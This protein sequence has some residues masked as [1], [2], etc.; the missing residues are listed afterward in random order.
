MR[1]LFMTSLAS[2]AGALAIAFGM[3]LSGGLVTAQDGG[4]PTVT[5]DDVPRPAH[6]HF[7]T[8][9]DLGNIAFP[10][11]D[12]TG[13]TIQG[14]PEAS[15]IVEDVSDPDVVQGEVV[16]ES[17]TDVESNWDALLDETAT[18]AIN[19]HDSADNMGLYIACGD[20]TGEPQDGRLEIDLQ[21]L[22]DSGFSGG[23]V[24]EETGD[25]TVTV[26]VTLR[27]VNDMA[28]PAS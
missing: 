25:N 9:D 3:L 11:Q 24:L 28:T 4:T 15:P 21:E 12:L 22:N 20:I 23:A 17:I 27:D 8:C 14:S 5:E 2:M 7:N 16:I 1:R 26:T 10:L 18:Y 19:V 13:V 6:I